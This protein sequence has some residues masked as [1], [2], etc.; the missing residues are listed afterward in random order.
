[1]KIPRLFKKTYTAQQLDKKILKHVYQKADAK[2]LKTR[3][4]KGDDDKYRFSTDG[5]EKKD[6]RKLKELAKAIKRNRSGL[7]RGKLIFVALV[8]VAGLLFSVFFKDRLVEQGA[9]AALSA[10]FGAPA[11]MDG[12]R[13]SLVRGEFSFD[14]LQ[15]YDA[16]DPGSYL[17]ELGPS[18]VSFF[19]PALAYRRVLVPEVVGTG[20]AFGT[21]APEPYTE[22]GDSGDPSPADDDAGGDAG[23]ETETGESGFSFAP[24]DFDAKAIVA[25]QASQFAIYGAVEEERAALERKKAE[26]ESEID[27]LEAELAS[28]QTSFDGLPSASDLSDLTALQSNLANARAVASS[29]QSIQNRI[30]DLDR[31]IRA[32]GDYLST[33]VDRFSSAYDTDLAALRSVLPAG[34]F[35][36]GDALGGYVESYLRDKIGPAYDWVLYGLSLVKKDGDDSERRPPRGTRRSGTVVNFPVT[37]FPRFMIQRMALSGDLGAFD[38]QHVSSD[39]DLVPEPWTAAGSWSWGDIPMDLGLAL[40]LRSDEAGFFGLDVSA[41]G[42][43]ISID[44]GLDGVG[45][46]SLAGSL[47]LVADAAVGK[48]ESGALR[49]DLELTNLNP[50]AAGNGAAARIVADSLAAADGLQIAA[51]AEIAN[52]DLAGWSVESNAGS[53]VAARADELGRQA[54]ADAQ[55][56]LEEEYSRLAE[57]Y[58]ADNPL[59]PPDVAAYAGDLSSLTGQAGGIEGGASGLQTALQDKVEDLGG[60]ASEAVQDAVK[61][62]LPTINLPGF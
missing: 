3:F 44:E 13:L 32:E 34:G 29:A 37:Q 39:P 2:F 33:G 22:I 25:E 52:A 31:R 35:D 15:V 9:E 61:D 49:I 60:S 4:K 38:V 28:L 57:Q 23:T 21:A 50:A 26:W 41:S 11:Q 24:A 54:L 53:L 59:I 30:A 10:A 6:A 17:F 7:K 8:V 27:T 62:A 14:A 43:P 36:A 46:A 20:L 18:R 19:W 48:D 45:L 1:V 12:G 58:L 42:A 40:D 47:D 16:R 5:L 56:A 51:T 55:A